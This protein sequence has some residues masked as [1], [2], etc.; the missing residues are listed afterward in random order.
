MNWLKSVSR[1]TIS[2]TIHSVVSWIIRSLV[3]RGSWLKRWAISGAWTPL[4]NSEEGVLCPK[5]HLRTLKRLSQIDWWVYRFIGL[6]VVHKT[7][8]LKHLASLKSDS[9]H[10]LFECSREKVWGWTESNQSLS[11]L[12]ELHGYAKF[13]PS[14]TDGSMDDLVFINTI[15]T[16]T[17]AKNGMSSPLGNSPWDSN[18][19]TT[20][21]DTQKVVWSTLRSHCFR[22][23]FFS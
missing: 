14:E 19:I 5:T 12:R 8:N 20:S 9:L 10:I 4:L 17:L 21:W 16:I 13:W 7:T 1:R 15:L 22:L 18:T 11:S 6:R 3:K 2:H 23:N